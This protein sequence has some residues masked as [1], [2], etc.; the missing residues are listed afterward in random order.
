VHQLPAGPVPHHRRDAYVGGIVLII[1]GASLLIVQLAPDFA[2]YVVTV[3]GIG[4]LLLFAITRSYGALIGGS[5][6]TG[7]GLGIIVASTYTGNQAAA[8][9]LLSLAVGFLFIWLASY[10]FRLTERHPWPLIPATILGSIGAVLA[11]GA[12]SSN[13][14]T[15]WPV[16]LIVLGVVV[17]VAAFLRREEATV[18]K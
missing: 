6:V 7:V 14:L 12:S 8:G 4:L 5:I 18:N 17:I 15:Y 10:L 13:L 2:R 3:I 11:I 9:F 1:I 16:I